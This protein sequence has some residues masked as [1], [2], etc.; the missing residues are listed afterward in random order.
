MKYWIYI[1]ER[2]R[3]QAVLNIISLEVQTTWTFVLQGMMLLPSCPMSLKHLHIILWLN[4]GCCLFYG[5]AAHDKFHFAASPVLSFVHLFK[6][7]CILPLFKKKVSGKWKKLKPN[8]NYKKFLSHILNINETK[9][10]VT[11]HAKNG[12]LLIRIN[13]LLNLNRSNVFKWGGNN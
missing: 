10:E 1:L 2:L 11:S 3:S 4:F 7:Y 12:K 8:S 5:G 6:C 9:M 13:H